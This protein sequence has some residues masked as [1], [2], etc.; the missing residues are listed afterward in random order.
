MG[1]PLTNAKELAGMKVLHPLCP[2]CG[3]DSLVVLAAHE[4]L[5]ACTSAHLLFL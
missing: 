2:E 3:Y 5:Y 1:R 4:C